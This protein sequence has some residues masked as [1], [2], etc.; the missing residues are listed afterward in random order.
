MSV[1]APKPTL[2]ERLPELYRQRDLEQTPLA[3]LRGFV[4]AIDSVLQALAAQ[5]GAQYDDLFIDSCADWVVAYLAD[6]VGTSHLK[7]DP[8][9]LRADV[10]RTVKNRRRKGT[11]GAVESQVHA[12]SGWA[13]HAIELRERM[14]W[15]QPL[16]HLRPDVGGGSPFAR[17]PYNQMTRPIRGGTAALRSPAWLSFVGSPFDPF[18]RV[19][20]VKPPLVLLDPP[21][22]RAAPNLPNLGV[23]LW[24]LADY[25]V[26][27]SRPSPPLAPWN[28][29]EAIPVSP[30]A[31]AFAVRFELHPQGEPMV[32]FNTFR[33]AAD[34]EPPNLASIDAVPGPMPMARLTSGDPAGNPDAYVRVETYAAVPSEPADDAPGLVL[35]LPAV[36]F[37][38]IPW[39][40][41]GAELC[42]WEE[43]LFPPLRP[44][45]IA[46]DP[47]H[48]RVVFGVTG[49]TSAA[50]AD[51]LITGLRVSATTGA[52]GARRKDGSV[53]A[54]PLPRVFDPLPAGAA[55]VA[56]DGV[57]TTLADALANL[58]ART[59]PLVVEIVNS[60]THVLDL[61]SVA[62]IGNV[63]GVF[64]L[65]LPQPQPD[66]GGVRPW[67]LTIR[68]AS[69]ERPVIRL[70]RP[71]CVRPQTIANA[72]VDLPEL[73]NVRLQG[74][75]L[76][77]DT[78]FPAGS[79]LIEQAVVNRLEID[80]CTLDPGGSLVLDGTATGGRASLREALRLS[81]SL[82]LT[83]AQRT[84]F[85]QT[86]EISLRHSIC[87]A[88]AIDD[89]YLIGLEACIV[90]AGAGVLEGPSSIAIGAATGNPEKT[91]AAPI[92]FAGVTVFGRSRVERAR[93]EGALFVRRL[94]VH[95]NQDSHVG[96]LFA[97]RSEADA[98][99]V[100]SEF[101]KD[102]SCIRAS[103]FSG[104]ADRLPQHVGCVF[105]PDATLRFNAER[106][107]APA[108]A[109]LALASDVR[110]RDDGPNADEMGAFGFLLGT[111]KWKN[112][113]IRLREFA[114][115][116]V[117]V[118]LI[119]VT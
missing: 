95:D 28:A 92:A 17:A 93:G 102:G 36:P 6:L 84:A 30:G 19:A 108:Y 12:L 63:G 33:Y 57:T 104:D 54:Q 91:W 87:G 106:F 21:V 100:F 55:F 75:Y 39:S 117:R 60:D 31:A 96:P 90:D 76:T 59:Q 9:T 69:G 109:Q 74:L 56:V 118:L 5:V 80:G 114:P 64:S 11:L 101:A 29:V 113:G 18:A 70:A 111:H 13:V 35:H 40:L 37:A 89:A 38:G 112:I 46:V 51:P 32:L 77:R 44:F 67:P 78:T 34:A 98:S 58:A 1:L 85:G 105:G 15:N 61:G 47:Q 4:G 14:A 71:F 72:S 107:G 3:P 97:V 2:Y 81:G 94:E 88:I 7:G 68:A 115:V 66:V 65:R 103:W 8:W 41:R 99:D 16:N 50:F 20:D 27:L 73:Q 24:R 83:T 45:E 23:F 22:G 119:P 53:G 10:A 62:G 26:P 110:I 48:G 79:A 86:P 42:A 43:G 52:V 82:G 25:Q 116:G 49:A